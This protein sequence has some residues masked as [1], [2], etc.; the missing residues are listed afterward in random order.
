MLNGFDRLVVVR[1]D[2]CSAS[3]VTWSDGVDLGLGS[4]VYM[5]FIALLIQV[6]LPNKKWLL[7]E[8]LA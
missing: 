2:M 3:C 5:C 1:V 7:S 4:L 6:V 8:L